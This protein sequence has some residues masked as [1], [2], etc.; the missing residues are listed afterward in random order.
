[1]RIP[2]ECELIGEKAPVVF[3]C[4]QPIVSCLA[5]TGDC[6]PSLPDTHGSVAVISTTQRVRVLSF[7]LRSRQP[8]GCGSPSVPDGGNSKVLAHA[9]ANELVEKTSILGRFLSPTPA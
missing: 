2:E 1:M 7:P 4:L 6:L 9:P 8:K 3:R 5:Q